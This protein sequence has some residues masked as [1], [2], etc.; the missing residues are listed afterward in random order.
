M[1]TRFLVIY[2]RTEYVNQVQLFKVHV[3]RFKQNS[4]H[5]PLYCENETANEFY[6][7][8]DAHDTYMI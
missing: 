3:A 1:A 8:I 7:T 6:H 4:G 5:L 2:Q